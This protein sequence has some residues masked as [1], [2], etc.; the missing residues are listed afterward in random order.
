MRPGQA[1]SSPLGSPD[2]NLLR[3][4]FLGLGVLAIPSRAQLELH[5]P[6]SFTKVQAVEGESVVL[7]A[8]YTLQGGMSSTQPGEEPIVMWFLEKRGEDLKQVLAFINGVLTNQPGASLVYNMPF[9]NVSLRLD[10]LQEQDSGS[11]RCSV[12]VQDSRGVNKG[13]SSKTIELNVL[14]P[15]ET[16][17]CRLLGVP[18]LGANV[19]LMCQSPRSKPAAQY[20]WKGP[21]PSS[22]VF[23]PPVSD[24]N[25]GS[26]KLSNLSLAMSGVY[27]CTAHNMVGSAQCN[28]TLEVSTDSGAAVVAGAVVGTL[29]GLVLLAGLFLLYQRR[30]KVLEEPANDIK[31]DAV[32]PRTLTWPKGSDTISKNETLSSVTSAR[33]LR[34]PHSPSRAGAMTPTPSL[35]SQALS[36]PRLPRTEEVPSQPVSTGPGGVSSSTLSR[37]GAV[38][39]MVP[40]QSQAWSL[41]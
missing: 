24:A 28:V 25:R 10:R 13:H 35:S 15:P 34:S 23:F 22:K 3:L 41:V 18:R 40:A 1:M 36:S 39:V 2:A 37:M 30:G 7:P 8:W 26:L 17:S 21:P 29:L 38:P 27:I 6:A 31:E 12:N 33:A 20:Q 14:V 9:R 4:L 11:Y 16:P 32:A 5:V 19:T